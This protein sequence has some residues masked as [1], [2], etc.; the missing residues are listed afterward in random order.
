MLD[1]GL[2]SVASQSRSKGESHSLTYVTSD[3]ISLPMMAQDADLKTFAE[4]PISQPTKKGQ[5][6]SHPNPAFIKDIY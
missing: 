2:Q 5:P 1:A 6:S 3:K 4:L